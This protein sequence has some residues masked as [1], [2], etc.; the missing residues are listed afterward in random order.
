MRHEVRLN[1]KTASHEYSRVREAM[2]REK[3]LTIIEKMNTFGRLN[4]ISA[5]ALAIASA[6]GR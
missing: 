3:E 4:G 6:P 5:K 2:K 1:E